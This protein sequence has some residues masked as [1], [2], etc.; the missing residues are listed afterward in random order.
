MCRRKTSELVA[1]VSPAVVGNELERRRLML[2]I[3][4]DCENK[5]II[6]FV[7]CDLKDF[8]FTLIHAKELIDE[9]L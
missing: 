5:R 2:A 9:M 7:L 8:S 3:V 4:L 1:F 6:Y